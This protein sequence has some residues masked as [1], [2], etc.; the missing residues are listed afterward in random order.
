MV[1]G[2]VF[3]YG[4]WPNNVSV[5]SIRGTY[6][7]DHTTVYQGFPSL[8]LSVVSGNGFYGLGNRGLGNE[9]LFV[10]AGKE[11]EGY[12]FA[13]APAGTT[14][15]AAVRLTNSD[16]GA[17]L[18]Q[19]LVNITGGGGWAQIPFSFTTVAGTECVGIA[20]GSDPSVDCGGMGPQPGHVCV[21]CFGQFEITLTSPG[22]LTVNYFFLQP[23]QWARLPGLPVLSETVQWL[24]D[25]GITAIRQGGSFTQNAYYEWKNWRGVPYKRPSIGSEWGASLVSGWGPFE[26][27][28]LCNAVGFEPIITTSMLSSAQDFSDLV[29][30]MFGDA[31]TEW[32]AT[33]IADGHPSPYKA[34]YFELGNEQYNTNYVEQV[35]AMEAKAASLGMP[36][37]LYYMFP[38]NGGPNAQDAAKAEALGLKDHVVSDIHVG[39][40]GGMEAAIDLFASNPSYQQGAV[41]CETNP[42]THDFTRALQ[43]A[44][45]LNDFF[46]TDLPRMHARTASFC[47]E[48]SGHY[49]AF[50]QGLVFFLPN[51]TWGQP[52]FYVHKMI[53][54][55]WAPNVLNVTANDYSPSDL[56]KIMSAGLSDDGK[57]LVLRIA[58]PLGAL[59]GTVTVVGKSVTGASATQVCLQSDD[60]SAA[61]TPANPTLV[62]PGPASQFTWNGTI[63]LPRQSYCILTVQL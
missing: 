20:P 15:T 45:D 39:A 35:A 58:N 23:G 14:V 55:Q 21:K 43:E 12:F 48:R 8:T 59:N 49:D 22:Q 2:E 63:S 7:F 34:Y 5:G 42:S 61:N 44:M 62:S 18:A 52:P 19:Q 37:T 51:M 24:Q 60:M 11:Y 1:F 31:S 6:I 13:Q 41:N 28:D 9:G 4:L 27:I 25:M 53:T 40:S 33:R 29:E 38:S 54:Q 56:S 16:T 36:N 50:D 26:M 17:V 32:G 47:T 57:T 10:Q 30:Y 3:E 46:N